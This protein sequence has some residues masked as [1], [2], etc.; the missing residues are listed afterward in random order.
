MAQGPFDSVLLEVNF[1]GSTWTDITSHLRS[2]GSDPWTLR[3]GRPNEFE[4]VGPSTLSVMLDNF[5]GALMPD[6]PT[7]PYWPNVVEGVKI[8]LSGT[9]SAVTYPLF[10][11]YV[12]AWSP[13]FP[14]GDQNTSAVLIEATDVLALLERRE[15]SSG[16]VEQGKYLARLYSGGCDT[17]VFKPT[18][19]GASYDTSVGAN[20]TSYANVGYT[21]AGSTPGAATLIPARTNAGYVTAEPA[22]GLA[23][24]GQLTF[25]PSV[26]AVGPVLRTTP[27]GPPVQ[28]DFF[29]RVPVT[30]IPAPGTILR[31]AELFVAATPVMQLCV[32][33]N[34]G[35]ADLAVYSGAGVYQATLTA[36]VADDV[37]RKVTIYR[38][39]ATTFALNTNDTLATTVLYPLGLDMTTVTAAYFGGYLATT[40]GEGKQSY[41]CPMSIAGVGVR[42]AGGSGVYG[43]LALGGA[44]AISDSTRFDELSWYTRDLTPTVAVTGTDSR[45]VVRT[46]PQGRSALDLC[47]ELARTVGG[48][49]W[50]DGAGTPHL[51]RPDEMR[52]ST[53]EAT[54]TLELD[55]LRS[56]PPQPRR[57]VDAKPNQV[58]VVC[59]VGSVTV[60]DSAALAGAA[61]DET[62]TAACATIGEAQSVASLRMASSA[63]LR[64]S[65][66]VVDLA[67]AATNLYPLLTTL[68][69]GVRLRI[70]ALVSAV[71]GWRY[72]DVYVQGWQLQCSASS[73]LLT[74]DLSPADDPPE[75]MW[76]DAEYGRWAAGTTMTVTS[77]TAVGG[78]G[79]GTLVVT[80]SS[81]PTLTTDAGQY[82]MDLDWWGER[83]TITSAPASAVSPQTVT[84]TSRGVSPSVARVHAVGETVDVWRAG[85]WAF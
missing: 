23:L 61:K 15:M 69:P 32:I 73:T 36:G 45:Q 40:A 2:R 22:D 76:D 68:R 28:I 6:N 70:D 85:T 64:L 35:V 77:G 5:D 30:A 79:N 7:S 31:V 34:A 42:T 67:N 62:I 41:C 9:E 58:T 80:T 12:T 17:F 44:P 43:Y 1:S 51:Y 19:A 27:Q 48:V 82:P 72:K 37:W 83:V 71:W 25:T 33:Y 75:A 59:P 55:D 18:G 11:G 78:T 52:P 4:E 38:Y 63:G 46:D 13:A 60:V 16:Y 50:V 26:T 65:Q 47:R 84:T 8:R 57:A 10:Y 56:S 49:I 21:P 81:G 24:E 29:L 39:D 14:T 74:L 3:S 20:P 53:L 66:M 54:I